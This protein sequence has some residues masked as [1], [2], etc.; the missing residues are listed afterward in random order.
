MRVLKIALVIVALLTIG[1]AAK[2]VLD[3]N[4]AA[5]CYAEIPYYSVLG[6]F[7]PDIG[8]GPTNPPDPLE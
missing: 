5:R 4:E 1:V 7:C 2:M 8:H 6:K 3:D